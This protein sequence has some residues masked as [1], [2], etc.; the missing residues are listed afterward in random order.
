[1]SNTTAMITVST[2]ELPDA[3]QQAYADYKTARHY[4][5][6]A[7]RENAPADVK[8]LSKYAYARAAYREGRGLLIDY[9]ALIAGCSER[10]VMHYAKKLLK[11]EATS[12]TYFTNNE[13]SK[14]MSSMMDMSVA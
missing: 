6:L 1:M 12:D 9:L 5:L 11:I 14:I 10:H 3:I 13:C 4:L 8:Y 7:H 2:I